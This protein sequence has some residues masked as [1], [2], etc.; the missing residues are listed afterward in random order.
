VLSGTP[1][2]IT[3]SASYVI[4]ASNAQGSGSTSISITV[5]DT[6][7]A[8]A[9]TGGPY[10]YTKGTAISALNAVSTG[11]TITGCSSSPTLPA[12][13]SI[14]ATCN[15][16]GTPTAVTSLANYTITATNTGGSGTANIT[17]T[18]NDV[19]PNITIAGSP[20]T[21]TK[22]TLIT[23]VTA[24]NTGGTITG[25]SSSPVLPSGLSSV[26]AFY[27]PEPAT[28]KLLRGRPSSRA[29]Q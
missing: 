16:T 6:P 15:I 25:C 24:T 2:A 5:N 29:S 20:F 12:G 4:S 28:R 8:I 27:D 13:L 21:F 11:G 9:Y 3:A 14:S 18:V 26:Y 7:P 10:V 23:T 22:G 1:S 19:A 17:I